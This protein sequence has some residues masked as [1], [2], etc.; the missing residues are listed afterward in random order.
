VVG[1]VGDVRQRSPS[2][3]MAPAVFY[4]LAQF[5]QTTMTQTIVVR[6]DAAIERVV[7]GIRAAVARVDADQPIARAAAM[8]DRIAAALAP[9]RFDLQ[10]VG[11]FAAAALLLA[12]VGIYG[13]VAFAMAA[14]TREIG[15]RVALGAAPRHIARLAL[16][17]GA[18]PAGA[19]VIAGAVVSLAGARVMESLVFGVTPRDPIAL[20]AAVLLVA[21][22]AA[23]AVAAPA[24]RAVRVD[25]MTA[26][27][28]E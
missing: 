1:V 21:A 4:P 18:A 16:V 26:L 28:A 6:S 12:G 24:R 23:A 20:A 19:G 27:R 15:V 25:P 10:L 9:R 14:R 11:A 13:I 5:P 22:A 3:D 2:A 7:D 17:S 8:P